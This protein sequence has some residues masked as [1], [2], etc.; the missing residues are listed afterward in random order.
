MLIVLILLVIGLFIEARVN[1]GLSKKVADLR[2]RYEE[3]EKEI[4]KLRVKNAI[5]KRY[6]TLIEKVKSG[7]SSSVNVYVIDSSV[8]SEDT[9]IR[10]KR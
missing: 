5:A 4:D 7:D 8:F 3:L 9:T 6:I 10:A 1:H 2:N